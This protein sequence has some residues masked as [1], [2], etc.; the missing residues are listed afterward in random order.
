[1][2]VPELPLPYADSYMI[3]G[4]IRARAGQTGDFVALGLVALGLRVHHLDFLGDD[5][6]ETWCAPCTGRRASR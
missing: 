2:Y 5:P 6:E 3:D 1:M 4:G